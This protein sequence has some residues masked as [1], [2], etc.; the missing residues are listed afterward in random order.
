MN[1]KQKLGYMILGAGIMGIGIIIGQFITPDIDAQ[2]NG[3]FDEIV[4]Q[5]LTVFDEKGRKAVAVIGDNHSNRI[6]IFDKQGRQ[7]IGLAGSL[8]GDGNGVLISDNTGNFAITLGSFKDS[9]LGNG[10]SIYDKNTRELAFRLYSNKETN[11]MVCYR[12]GDHDN[13]PAVIL[14]SLLLGPMRVNTIGFHNES[15]GETTILKD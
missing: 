9:L 12:K 5:K 14:N 6:E 7:A 15:T 13:L 11:E 4:C 3:V 2:S 8:S 1:N 10:I